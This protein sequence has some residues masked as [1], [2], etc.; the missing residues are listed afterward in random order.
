MPLIF[1]EARSGGTSTLAASQAS[2]KP[3][4]N[5]SQAVAVTYQRE[6]M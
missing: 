4:R 1:C 5:S 6:E 2:D 3:R